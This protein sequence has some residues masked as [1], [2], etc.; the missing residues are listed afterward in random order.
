LVQKRKRNSVNVN[1]RCERPLRRGWETRCS[2]EN[3]HTSLCYSF[4]C[5]R[6]P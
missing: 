6:Q 4:L 1:W 3:S 2:M 5:R